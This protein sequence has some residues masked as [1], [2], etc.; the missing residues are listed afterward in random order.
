MLML[1]PD[2]SRAA[3][4]DDR[5]LAHRCRWGS[6]TPSVAQLEP[7]LQIA[8]GHLSQP[9]HAVGKWPACALPLMV[10]RQATYPQLLHHWSGH[11]GWSACGRDMIAHTPEHRCRSRER[12][13]KSVAPS[14]RPHK[15]TSWTVPLLGQYLHQRHGITV[16]AR[17]LR[18]RLHGLDHWSKRLPLEAASLRL[19][20]AGSASA[21][22]KGGLIRRLRA[23]WRACDVLLCC[24]WTLLRLFPPL[25]A[26][27]ARK[28][29]QA[30]VPITGANAKRV[31]F[32]AINLRTAHRVVLIRP[33]AGAADAQAFLREIRRRY[34]A[35]GTIW[36]LA[37]R[38]S[39]HTAARTQMLAAALGI[40][41]LWLPKQAPE[42]NAMDQLWR[43][44]KRLI[45]ANR[46][47][48]S[49]DALASNAAGWVLGLTPQQARRKAGMTSPHFWLRNLVQ[50][51]WLPT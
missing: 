48:A 36:L 3:C 11:S 32:G 27:W 6:S 45:A 10:A 38:A 22:E 37:D 42:L 16:R 20:R 41:F 15:A 4:S 7:S 49:A 35:A 13:E 30:T 2:G 21:P 29:T 39:A 24:D 14:S 33:R 5:I 17:T 1:I 25:R 43:E 40:R 8:G 26:A 18:R 34:R 44:L 50:D 23:G 46:Q 31:L 19:C 47:A 9:T 28:G 12:D 51:F